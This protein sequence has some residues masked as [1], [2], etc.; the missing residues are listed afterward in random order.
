MFS[1]DDGGV[2]WTGDHGEADPG[3]RR[4]CFARETLRLVSIALG[5]TELFQQDKAVEET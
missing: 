1:G 3:N 4:E 2:L 5:R